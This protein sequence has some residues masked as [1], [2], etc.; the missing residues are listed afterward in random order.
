MSSQLVPFRLADASPV[1]IA[2]AGARA[3]E[4]F[5]EFFTRSCR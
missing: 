1:L 4:R 5:V 3:Q 2:A